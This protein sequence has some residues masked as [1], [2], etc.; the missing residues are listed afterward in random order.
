M[1][2]SLLAIAHGVTKMDYK[3]AFQE[4]SN[5]SCKHEQVWQ[6]VVKIFT[7]VLLVTLK[8]WSYG[9]SFYNYLNS[10]QASGE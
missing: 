1:F 4:Q 10:V 6:H 7:F 2:D 3:T 5:V 9:S 8:A